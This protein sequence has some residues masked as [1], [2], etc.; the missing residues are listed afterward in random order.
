M[1]IAIFSDVHGN[2]IAL[3]A[4]L[5]D[6][7]AQGGVD[8]CWVLGDLAA[9]GYDPR[10]AL[11][12]IFNLPNVKIIHGNADRYVYAP[13][14]LP[15]DEIRANLELLPRFLANRQDFAWTRGV[16]A[17]TDWLDKLAALPL[18]L[19]TTLPDGTR[20]LGV[21]ASPGTDDGV[22]I[23]PRL[24]AEQLQNLLQGC[25]ADLVF[26]GHT[27]W[28][29]EAT[30][31]HMQ[32]VN[33]GSVSLPNPPDLRAKYIILHA[34]AASHRIERRF[35]DYDHNAVIAILEKLRPPAYEMVVRSMRGQQ[36]VAW[37]NKLS[38]AEAKQ[39]GLPA[40]LVDPSA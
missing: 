10:G 31:N 18:E 37:S 13:D 35:V 30:S 26:V 7:Q 6:I 11:E 24:S 40:V 3:D 17:Y 36:R 34:D 8:E 19:R 28:A 21:H 16:L 29:M 12:R 22:G 27:H 4:V 2:T 38:A 33:L 15:L 9:L 23:H 5:A 1:R 20:V 32:V 25:D 14:P 39:L